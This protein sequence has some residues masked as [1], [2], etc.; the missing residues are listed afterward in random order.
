MFGLL[1]R[2][3]A[4]KKKYET[5][6]QGLPQICRYKGNLSSSDEF[7]EDQRV[8]FSRIFVFMRYEGKKKKRDSDHFV[9]LSYPNQTYLYAVISDYNIIGAYIDNTDKL[10]PLLEATCPT[11]K[12]DILEEL[13]KTFWRMSKLKRFVMLG[14]DRSDYFINKYMLDRLIEIP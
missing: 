2:K 9:L 8:Y 5:L 7:S 6:F 13:K 12:A 14:P 11:A 4:W 3:P 1:T 10:L